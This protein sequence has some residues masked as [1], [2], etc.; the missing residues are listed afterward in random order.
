M[1][2]GSPRPKATHEGKLNFPVTLQ[3]GESRE[4]SV[5][6][7]SVDCANLDNDVRVLSESGFLQVIG[8]S[9]A[10]GGT[11]GD[12]S[13]KLPVFLSADNLKPFIDRHLTAPTN[14]VWY[15]PLHGG[16][17]KGYLAELLPQVC[18]IY[19]EANRAGVLRDNQIHIAER[20]EAIV[21][22]LINVAIVAL[23]DEATGYQE[24]RPKTELQAIFE[25][26]LRRNP[27]PWKRK[28]I[29]EFYAQIH[30]LKQ[31]KYNSYSS[32]RSPLIG[33]ITIDV[34]YS[35]IQPE[36]WNEL[37]KRNPDKKRYKYHQ[38]L[39]QNIGSAHLR[40]HLRE[41]TRLMSICNNW[42]QFKVFLDRMHPVCNAIQMDI[43]FDLLMQSSEDFEKWQDLTS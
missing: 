29:E 26:Y 39:T 28:F 34:V 22:A 10:P 35:R 43:F 3:N 7:I 18:Q 11:S 42:N 1:V 16:K 23:V 40:N 33:K 4:F 14:P 41:V 21:S 36:L 38:F 25:M 17:A 8:R 37:V 24:V 19:W 15:T 13:D 30:P 5:L 31:W 27:E 32:K 6:N 12:G 2:S 9:K 20:C